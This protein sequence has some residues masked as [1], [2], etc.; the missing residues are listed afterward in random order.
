MAKKYNVYGMGNALVD[1]V[2]E[3]DEAF[4]NTHSIEKGFM[5]LVDEERQTQLME[6]I[7]FSKSSMKCGGS[8]ANTV[9]GASQFGASCF[10]S[11]K[12]ANDEWGAFYLKDLTAN[13]IDTVLTNEKLS[14]GITG[15]CLVM[16]TA[17]AERT[18]NTFLGITA[19]YSSNEIDEAALRDSEYLYIEGYLVTSDSARQAMIEAKQIAETNGTQTA[20]TFS[21]PSM[22]KYFKEQMSEVIGSGMDLLFCNEEEAMLYTGKDSIESAKESLKNA[23]KRY[24]ITLGD[25]GAVL[26]DGQEFIEIEAFPTE[27]VDTNGAGDL[28][29]GAFLYGITNDMSYAHAGKLA[30]K[31]SS[32]VVSQFG[33]RLEKSQSQAIFSELFEKS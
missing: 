1:I 19:D 3:V 30:S 21:D 6:A 12:V 8:A 28:F 13:G 31:A 24:A 27:A 4:I 7:D 20:L 11:C 15:K 22:V 17:D 18:M 10:Y 29:A 33:P 32:S 16:T 2:T 25:K 14:D 23:A 26:F 5:T 9:I